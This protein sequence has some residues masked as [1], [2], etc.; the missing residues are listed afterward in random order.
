MDPTSPINTLPVFVEGEG[1]SA[2]KFS[3]SVKAINRAA[4]GVSAPQ[5]IPPKP[6]KAGVESLPTSCRSFIDDTSIALAG[7]FENDGIMLAVGDY[8]LVTRDQSDDGVYLVKLGAWFRKAR[9][10]NLHGNDGARVY[11]KGTLITVW[12]GDSAPLVYAVCVD[13][14]LEV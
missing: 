5:Q 10:S 4:N 9:L 2:S 11:D 6:S 13:Q 14:S 8:V 7:V 1:L 3:N 12:D